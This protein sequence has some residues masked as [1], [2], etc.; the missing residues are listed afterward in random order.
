MSLVVF[1]IAGCGAHR[2]AGP[3]WPKQH[4]VEKDGGESLAPRTSASVVT[5]DSASDDKPT[6]TPAPTVKPTTTTPAAATGGTTTT[7]PAAVTPAGIED[8]MTTEEIVIEI[9]GD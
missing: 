3:A 4:A 2:D 9:D 1:L 5:A 7:T 8:P 6:E